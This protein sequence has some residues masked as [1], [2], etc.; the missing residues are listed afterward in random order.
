MSHA[1]VLP[2]TVQAATNGTA[3]HV[4]ETNIRDFVLS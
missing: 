4:A 3:S 2:S 1:Q